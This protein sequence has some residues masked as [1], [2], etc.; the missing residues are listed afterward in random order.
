MGFGDLLRMTAEDF[1]VLLRRVAP[2]ITKRDTQMRLAIT[3][4][5]R[6]ALTLRFSTGYAYWWL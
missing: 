3:A 5:E 6:L 4:K 2:L 1:E